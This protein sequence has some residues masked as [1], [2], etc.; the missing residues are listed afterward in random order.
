[1]RIG[2]KA[3]LVDLLLLFFLGIAV[4]LLFQTSPYQKDM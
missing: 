3:L 4:I 2:S 1:M